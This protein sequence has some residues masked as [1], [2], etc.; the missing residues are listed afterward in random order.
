LIVVKLFDIN[1]VFVEAINATKLSWTRQ[2][3]KEYSFDIE[4]P[5]APNSSDYKV[6]LIDTESLLRVIPSGYIT[7]YDG[8]TTIT[9][10]SWE[11]SIGESC[12]VPENWQWWDR[13]SLSSIIADHCYG[14][15][16]LS[17][18]GLPALQ[19]AID[20]HNVVMSELDA[21]NGDVYLDTFRYL[22]SS[23]LAYDE[24]GYVVYKIPVPAEARRTGMV[25][26]WKDSVGST[27]DI[28][29]QFGWS[30]S[31]TASG[32]I[33]SAEQSPARSDSVIPNQTRGVDIP[34]GH[35]AY[36]Y[37]RFNLKYDAGTDGINYEQQITT[38]TG[39][40][41][42]IVYYGCTPILNAF[43]VIYRVN[44][45]V[46]PG[47]ITVGAT[48]LTADVHGKSNN[49][50]SLKAIAE[51]YDIVF[52]CTTA[53]DGAVLLN[54]Y[55]SYVN[56]M[57]NEIGCISNALNAT[58]SSTKKDLNIYDGCD[59]YGAGDGI[60]RLHTFV[61]IDGVTSPKNITTFEDSDITNVEDLS[62][63][64]LASLE[65]ENAV[66]TT[67]E[68][69]WYGSP[70][71]QLHDSIPV[72]VSGSIYTDV[73]SEE[74]FTYDSNGLS[75]RSYVLGIKTYPLREFLGNAYSGKYLKTI[76][77]PTNVKATRGSDGITV[78]WL[79]S[80]PSYIVEYMR[81]G[82]SYYSRVSADSNSI[83]IPVIEDSTD[84]IFRVYCVIDNEIGEPAYTLLNSTIA[85]NASIEMT[86]N[87]PS[88]S[89]SRDGD[90][91]PSS[92]TALAIYDGVFPYE[93]FYS[94]DLSSD[95]STYVNF[96]TSPLKESSKTIS[97]PKMFE[98]LGEEYYTNIVRIRLYSDAAK[99]NIKAEKVVS[100]IADIST[101]PIYYGALLSPP[102]SETL[103]NDYY[104]D[105]N[106]SELGGGVLKYWDGNSWEIMTSTRPTY[107]EAINTAMSDM[108]AW[109]TTNSGAIGSVTAFVSAVINNL[110]AK[111]A[112]INYL[113]TSTQVSTALCDDGVTRRMEIDWDNAIEY[114]RNADQSK[115][116]KLTDALVKSEIGSGVKKRSVVTDGDAISW[117]DT[118]SGGVQSLIARISRLGVGSDRA[119]MDGK[120]CVKSE[121]AWSTASIISVIHY[122]TPSP[123]YI[124]LADGTLR[125]AYIRADDGYIVERIYNMSTS[126]WGSETVINAALSASP[127]Y[128]QL[129]DG[130]LRIAY[131]RS[132]D[133]YIVERI[134]NMSTSAWGSETVINAAFSDSPAYVQLAD[135]TLRIAYFSGSALIERIYNMST[136]A[137]G[138][139]TVINAA[140]SDNP[141]YI[142]LADG[143]LRIVYQDGSLDNI[144]ERTKEMYSRIAFGRTR[145]ISASAT[146]TEGD[147]R[148]V[149]TTPN[150]V[151]ITV[152]AGLDL[153]TGVIISRTV[154][155]AASIT[156]ATSGS[157]TVEGSTSFVTHGAQVASTLNPNEVTMRK[158]E[159]G[160]WRFVAG[161]VSGSNGNGSYQLFADGNANQRYRIPQ[162][163]A[164]G[165]NGWSAWGSEGGWYSST[166]N[167][168]F[169][170]PFAADL[171]FFS[172][173][174]GD[175]SASQAELFRTYNAT[176]TYC[177]MIV[178][179]NATSSGNWNGCSVFAFGRWRAA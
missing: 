167:W 12:I 67:V 43:E 27:T 9:V 142:Q 14:F 152:P 175:I 145:Y 38:V 179:C 162:T 113:A 20:S 76:P 141:D 140:L 81:N 21:S 32:V 89:R 64:G 79:G 153:Q 28:S 55:S 128:V 99:T 163:D 110:I 82:A 66:D 3:N 35:L 112:I 18:A 102:E 121:S 150:A 29:V 118:P 73:L 129:A 111:E 115:I 11:T 134:R 132:S 168:F 16:T 10:S 24:L 59:C 174:S 136:S 101:V 172:C 146:L 95:G 131:R 161:I 126:A 17:Y 130:T 92:V 60:D 124:Q 94:V 85:R 30:D 80:T 58:V 84:Y 114:L 135:G 62:A 120:F 116:V 165:V 149:V 46:S 70:V 164:A 87:V 127:A 133:G 49:L 19:S 138:S 169:P 155:S 158:T 2:K 44:T 144:A 170:V 31:P 68:F 97:P 166:K 147:E 88:F 50:E 148:I 119:L 63:A 83:T 159:S 106:T 160:K 100:V 123:T 154:S 125:I 51:A 96:Y 105:K 117:Y 52:F 93:G 69:E 75:K 151:T 57:K 157:E 98:L 5:S 40:T 4:L 173:M 143:T 54:A 177:T 22:S 34:E 108:V 139:E 36:I 13:K 90:L 104:F 91:E 107:S 48:I 26:R 103:E 122:Q 41:G 15:R 8:G 1:G 45:N 65:A 171:E 77:V 37:V 61:K 78:S 53:S 156:F 56:D 39:S 137:W 23:E 25:L 72:N 47:T 7:D 86:V 74:S 33:Y 42:N 6:Q 178:Q 109:C 176:R 71:L